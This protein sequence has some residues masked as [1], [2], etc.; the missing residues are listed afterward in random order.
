M[1]IS[2]KWR[3]IF[4]NQAEKTFGKLDRPVQKEIEKY[5]SKRVLMAEH[6]RAL[7][8]PLKGN[9]SDYWRYWL[10]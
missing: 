4:S 8:E 2:A 1:M 7:G 6:P 3:I 10:I 9:I 5:L